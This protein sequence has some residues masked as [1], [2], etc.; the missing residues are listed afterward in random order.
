M[1]PQQLK[2]Q[3]FVKISP[4]AMM[5]RLNANKG[6]FYYNTIEH[7]EWCKTLK[8]GHGEDC[9]CNP[10]ESIWLMREDESEH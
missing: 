3:G 5:K 4:Q 1:T 6:G 9:N 8:T 10:T 7:D 2:E